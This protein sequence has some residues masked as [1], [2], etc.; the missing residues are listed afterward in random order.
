MEEQMIVPN[1]QAEM[2][3]RKMTQ[4]TEKSHLSSLP[5]R[6]EI[7]KKKKSKN[8][9]KLRF[10]VIR[11]LTVIFI[12]LPIIIYSVISYIEQTNKGKHEPAVVDPEFIQVDIENDNK[13]TI[14][15]PNEE[16]VEDDLEENSPPS[17]NEEPDKVDLGETIE[18]IDASKEKNSTAT[19]Q[20]ASEE[21]KENSQEPSYQLIQHQVQPNETLFRISM[22]YYQSQE[23]IELIKKWNNIVNNEI[24]IGQILTI[25]IP[26]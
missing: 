6:S 12:L 22:K 14:E 26:Q 17:Q 15:I 11:F 9:W 13:G 23:G 19:N 3:R 10:P 20:E 7:H 24:K 18:P 1:D 25:P 21:N 2:L 16:K 5:P 4:E 8:K